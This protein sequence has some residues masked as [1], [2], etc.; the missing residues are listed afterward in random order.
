MKFAYHPFNKRNEM[1]TGPNQ[2]STKQHPP[3]HKNSPH[4]S[5]TS[6]L[7]NLIPTVATMTL[8][9]RVIDCIANL[10][11][12]IY[13]HAR[14]CTQN[15]RSGRKRAQ[16]L[17]L[18]ISILRARGDDPLRKRDETAA[19][20]SLGECAAFFFFSWLIARWVGGSRVVGMSVARIIVLERFWY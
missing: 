15:S 7:K 9:S 1:I 3:I 16:H 19:R 5:S 8:T 2:T 14:I 12:S 13:T 11:T 4:T 6:P 20:N 10:Y 17:S 18:S